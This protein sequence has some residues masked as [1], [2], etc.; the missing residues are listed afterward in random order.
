MHKIKRD[1]S[2]SAFT[3]PVH[4][5]EKQSETIS[6]VGIY[7]KWFLLCVSGATSAKKFVA[8]ARNILNVI[9]VI[10]TL[11][12]TETPCPLKGLNFFAVSGKSL[13][14]FFLNVG[15]FSSI[16]RIEAYAP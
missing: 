1:C 6:N 12:Y 3:F 8:N 16:L 7:F 15:N 14:G 2:E 4:C 11:R 5:Q 9:N 10:K 13:F